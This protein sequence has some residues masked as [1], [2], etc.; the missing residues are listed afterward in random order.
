MA[1]FVQKLKREARSLFLAQSLG[2]L[3]FGFL[4]WSG[5]LILLD[6][7]D[8]YSPIQEKN[9]HLWIIGA[10]V[11]S[12]LCF[13]GLFTRVC[14]KR[15]STKELARKVELAHPQLRDLLN[16]AVEIEKKKEAPQFMELRVLRHLEQ[17]ALLMDWG[18]GLRPSSNFVNYLSLIHI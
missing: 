13:M 11:I 7:F 16:S 1:N 15:P 12:G 4:A 5:L 6:L 10:V 14:F 2:A 8:A 3:V 9:A 17:K 18:K